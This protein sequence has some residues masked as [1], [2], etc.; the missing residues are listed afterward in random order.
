MKASAQRM[1]M[2][3]RVRD[4]AMRL[5]EANPHWVKARNVDARLRECRI[6]DLS[7]M[8]WDEFSAKELRT[9]GGDFKRGLEIRV[10]GAGKVF[11]LYWEPVKRWADP[12]YLM[13]F[14]R[15]AWVNRV[16]GGIK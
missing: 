1:E 10:D 8:A 16:L 4:E 11:C 3:K 15:G 12:E 5:L 2:A 14:K 13:T 6:D 9:G 7:I